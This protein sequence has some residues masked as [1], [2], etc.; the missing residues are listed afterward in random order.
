MSSLYPAPSQQQKSSFLKVAKRRSLE[1]N[2]YIQAI[3]RGANF[4]AQKFLIYGQGRTG[5]ELLC[6]LLDA[7]PDIQCDTEIFFHHI[8]LPKLLIKGKCNSCPKKAYGFKVKIYQLLDIQKK[9]P[10]QFLI[11][12]LDDRGKI[13]YLKRQN[14][15][16][17]GISLITARQRKQFH[18][19]SKNQAVKKEKINIDCDLLLAQMRD[20]EAYDDT[21]AKVLEGLPYIPIVYEDDLL[22]E[23]NHQATVDK[24]CEY[25]KITPTPVQTKF[26]KLTPENLS[27]LIANYDEV[28][29]AV[30]STKYAHFLEEETKEVK[31]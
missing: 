25:L 26:R 21:D 9:D 10:R 20:R 8:F 30:S 3:F 7:N 17:Q 6:S 14:L 16:R 22:K 23:E 5:S 19:K 29:Q 11:D 12:F 1:I 27:D 2:N 15:L 13:I 28:L 24:I 4:P 31:S 18:I